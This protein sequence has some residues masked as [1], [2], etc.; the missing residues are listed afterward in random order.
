MLIKELNEKRLALHNEVKAILALPADKVTADDKKKADVALLEMNSLQADIDRIKKSE[1][2]EAELRKIDFKPEAAPGD[3]KADEKNDKDGK[4]DEKAQTELE[5]R[6]FYKFCMRGRSI[7]TPE[8]NLVIKEQRTAEATTLGIGGELIPPAFQRSLE[9]AMKF[10]AP[11]TDYADVVSTPDG[12]PMIW[13]LSDSTGRMAQWVPEGSAVVDNDIETNKVIFGAYKIGDLVKVGL[14]INQDAF[15]SVDGLVVDAFA[16]SF[17]RALSLAFTTGT[18]GGVSPT[19]ILTA[20]V[21]GVIANGNDNLTVEPDP[22]TG[23][24]YLDVLALLHSVDPA[25]RN[26]PGASF[27]F[28]DS[29]LLALSSLKDLYGHPLWIPSFTADAPNQILGKPYIINNFMP[30]FGLS[31]KPILFGDLSRYK[32]RQ[33]K[34]MT[35][36][37]L[38]E[39]YAEYGQV[40]IIAWAR[41]D[42]NLVNAGQNPVKYMGTPTS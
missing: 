5:N 19:G 6:A 27:M 39:R 9:Q 16:Q 32:V 37:R 20:A 17:G 10:Y 22:L 15:T 3:K 42:G 13:P 36:Q 30:S 1:E 28:N 24:G 31:Q 25:Y 23:P 11:F 2:I 33:V 21:Q 12:A 8:E 40:G 7:L 26:Q 4:I 34:T 14:E 35:I 29:V 18:G 41:Y 38:V